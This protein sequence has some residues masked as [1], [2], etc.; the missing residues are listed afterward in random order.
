MRRGPLLLA[1]ALA[2]GLGACD[3]L[4]TLRDHLNILAVDFGFQR[5]D[6]SGLVY[7]STV[8]IARELLYQDL[9]AKANYGVDIRCRLVAHNPNNHAASFDGARV[10]LR[11]Q[12]TSAFAPAV[13]ALL[14]AF[15]VEAQAD[16]NLDIVFPLRL[17]NP[18]FS[19]SAWAQV[20]QGGDMPYRIDANLF[21]KLLDESTPG[22]VQALGNDS[23]HVSVAKGSVD[24][25]ETSASVL[26]YLLQYLELVF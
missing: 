5:V 17:D 14:P 23:V 19:Q 22:L 1:F 12:D 26:D 15:R 20:I 16:Q 3:F 10:F 13:S 24:A 21:F 8:E 6:V 11:V 25:R 9:S 7:P 4:D 18:V 2:L